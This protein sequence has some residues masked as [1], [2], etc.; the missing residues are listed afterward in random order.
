MLSNSIHFRK[1]FLSESGF[2]FCS[3]SVQNCD[4]S[5]VNQLFS[6]WFFAIQ[7]INGIYTKYSI[8]EKFG[9]GGV[10]HINLRCFWGVNAIANFFYI[11]IKRNCSL[12]IFWKNNIPKRGFTKKTKK[13]E[14]SPNLLWESQRN[15]K[16][17]FWTKICIFNDCDS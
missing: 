17:T 8:T 4:S 12:F 9:R 15:D 13:L 10:R 11:G 6:N 5:G 7:I 14:A 1:K 16:S 3:I 2:F